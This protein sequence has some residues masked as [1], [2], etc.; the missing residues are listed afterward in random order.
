M[1]NP[2]PNGTSSSWLMF[3]LVF[4]GAGLG[5]VARV[6]VGRGLVAL[7][8]DVAARSGFPWATLAVNLVG[9]G[10]IGVVAAA[11]LRAGPEGRLKSMSGV[12]GGL[13]ASSVQALVVAGLLGGFTTFS[14]LS[15]E[16]VQ[17]WQAGRPW[18]AGA[19][20]L[21][22]NLAGLAATWLALRAA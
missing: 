18:A 21:A 9:A 13:H 14:S 15:L 19:Y 16:A 20:V 12:G 3:A 6:L 2:E 7:G 5:G 11:L 22:T 17:L 10:A 4:V 1:A 8:V